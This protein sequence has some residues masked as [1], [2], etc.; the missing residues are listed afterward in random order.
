MK[1]SADRGD[2]RAAHLHDLEVGND[3]EECVDA[4]GHVGQLHDQ[5]VLG[6]VNDAALV[7]AAQL[8]DCLLYTSDAADE[9]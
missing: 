1:L 7:Q 3:V 8:T 2:A 5:L 9:L 6:R 4:A